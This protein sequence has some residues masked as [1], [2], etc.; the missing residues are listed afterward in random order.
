MADLFRNSFFFCDIS[1]QLI[2]LV[3]NIDTCYDSTCD[4]KFYQSLRVRFY[5]EC[6]QSPFFFAFPFFT[7][8]NQTSIRL[9]FG[10]LFQKTIYKGFGIRKLTLNKVQK[11]SDVISVLVRS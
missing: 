10:F 7:F 11:A 3:R 6:Y 1:D 5:G 2:I 4:W 8:G 9:F